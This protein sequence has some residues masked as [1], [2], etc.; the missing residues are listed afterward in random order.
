MASLGVLDKGAETREA[1]TAL[2][3]ALAQVGLLLPL[4]L[5]NPGSLFEG[6]QV[7]AE[8][9]GL[10]RLLAALL[11]KHGRAQIT[12]AIGHL[13]GPARKAASEAFEK[14]AASKRGM[15]AL[16]EP[17]VA[18]EAAHTSTESSSSNGGS[19]PS[20]RGAHAAQV[21]RPALA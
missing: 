8:A 13:T 18:L 9:V 2:M 4:L 12:A 1:G 7:P 3:L 5:E 19:R 6:L 11:Q 10:P 15:T 16:Q 17:G 20:S 21:G 14:V